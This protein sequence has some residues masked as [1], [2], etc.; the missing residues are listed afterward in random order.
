MLTIEGFDPDHG[1]AGTQVTIKGS[2]FQSDNN[3][4]LALSVSFNGTEAA[5]PTIESDTQMTVTV[6]QDATTGPISVRGDNNDTATSSTVSGH[7]TRWKWFGI[8]HAARIGSDS[9]SWA[10]RINAINAR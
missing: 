8:R 10:F 6:P 9:C 4:P 1:N 5:T 7:R 3:N 2:G